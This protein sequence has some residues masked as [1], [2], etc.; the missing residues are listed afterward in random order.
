MN[1]DFQGLRL[2][3]LPTDADADDDVELTPVASQTLNNKKWGFGN[4]AAAISSYAP[5]APNA[6]VSSPPSSFSQQL[7]RLRSSTVTRP[8]ENN[9]ISN[10]VSG[11]SRPSFSLTRS[12]STSESSSGAYSAM[13]LHQRFRSTSTITETND[14]YT[15]APRVGSFKRKSGTGSADF[16]SPIDNSSR[17]YD[18][19]V[20]NANR[21]SK[22]SSIGI[23]VR[24][25]SNHSRSSPSSYTPSLTDGETA[26]TG[27]EPSSPQ[28]RRISTSS[29]GS[30]LRIDGHLRQNT[31][32]SLSEDPNILEA[33][34]KLNGR[35]SA[36][37]ITA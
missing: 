31:L 4:I 1:P 5:A 24:T 33:E 17:P 19:S 34:A 27:S 7:A 25:A 11:W 6:T 13:N 30:N 22:R 2:P 26:V 20:R 32:A 36:P 18:I 8:G 35:S 37:M 28:M 15:P 3:P 9:T 14:N 23:D 21:N 10:F 16:S 12:Q 29:T